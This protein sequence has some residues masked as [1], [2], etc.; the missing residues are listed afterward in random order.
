M[1]PFSPRSLP[2]SEGVLGTL[3]PI[4]APAHDHDLHRTCLPG[5]RRRRLLDT[6]PAGDLRAE[7]YGLSHVDPP[8]LVVRLGA[9]DGVGLLLRLLLRPGV[10]QTLV[11][12]RPHTL[13]VVGRPGLQLRAHHKG[14]R[15]A[16]LRADEL[17]Q[18]M[19]VHT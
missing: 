11:R 13:D 3:R 6:D 4:N 19:Q 16:A 5:P 9:E 14:H 2:V 1:R 15:N 8:P 10:D 18:G 12:L 17:A 7:G